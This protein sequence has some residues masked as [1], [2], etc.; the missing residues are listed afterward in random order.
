M[1]PDTDEPVDDDYPDEA[2]EP[3]AWESIPAFVRFAVWVWAVMVVLGCVAL[4]A[5]LILLV[6]AG[7][8]LH[9]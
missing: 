2:W 6:Q 4:P 7:H 3:T 1:I 9:H 8:L 5:L